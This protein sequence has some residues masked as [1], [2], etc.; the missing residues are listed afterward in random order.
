MTLSVLVISEYN[1]LEVILKQ[2]FQNIDINTNIEFQAANIIINQNNSNGLNIDIIGNK[3]SWIMQK[4]ISIIKLINIIEQA[5]HTL[6]ENIIRIGPIDFYPE[7][8]LCK[9][10]SEEIILTTKETEIIFYLSQHPNQEIDKNTLLNQVWGYTENISTHTLETHIYKLRNK[11]VDKYDI[12]I[13]KDSGYSL[14]I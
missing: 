3:K 6:S 13:S 1:F 9:F 8:K 14:S 5:I 7:Q 10:G 4:P 11:F 12:I 2:Y